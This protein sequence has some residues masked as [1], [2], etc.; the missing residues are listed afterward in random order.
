LEDTDH[1][2]STGYRHI[3]AEDRGRIVVVRF[4]DLDSILQVKGPSGQETYRDF[5]QLANHHW[6]CSFVLDFQDQPITTDPYLKTEI[7]ITYLARLLREI[8]EAQGTLRLCNLPLPL[9]EALRAIRLDRMFSIC[10]SLDDALASN[11]TDPGQS[12]ERPR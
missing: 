11:V 7:C 3:S 8:K 2:I 10:E 5:H 12:R 9:M 6:T 1:S 4:I